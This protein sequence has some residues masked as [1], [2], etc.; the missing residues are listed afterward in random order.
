MKLQVTKEN[1]RNADVSQADFENKVTSLRSPSST[2]GARVVHMLNT[3]RFDDMLI[4]PE[5]ILVVTYCRS[6]SADTCCFISLRKDVK[7]V[8]ALN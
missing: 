5:R 6:V 2:T 3:L 8:S 1:W 7:E 4:A